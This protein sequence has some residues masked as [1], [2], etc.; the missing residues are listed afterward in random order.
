MHYGCYKCDEGLATSPLPKRA[1][2][3]VS[4]IKHLKIIKYS[5]NRYLLRVCYVPREIP[6]SQ[7][8]VINKT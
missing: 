5:L 7:D 6:N 1:G 4:V 3:L 8:I 2:S